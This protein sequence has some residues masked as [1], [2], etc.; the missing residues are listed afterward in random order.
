MQVYMQRLVKT[1]RATPEALMKWQEEW[2]FDVEELAPARL[3]KIWYHLRKISCVPTEVRRLMSGQDACKKPVHEMAPVY[4]VFSEENESQWFT[5]ISFDHEAFS[6]MCGNMRKLWKTEAY[7]GLD[8]SAIPSDA[9]VE[10]TWKFMHYENRHV[11]VEECSDGPVAMAEVLAATPRPHDLCAV[12]LHCERMLGQ[13]PMTLYT[14]VIPNSDYWRSEIVARISE[15][16]FE[17]YML[18][19][20]REQEIIIAFSALADLVY[21]GEIQKACKS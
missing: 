15:T 13:V 9:E 5:A 11:Q 10:R 17:K 1:D 16:E 20:H 8:F 4:I 21:D 19:D 18:T 14:I 6:G 7:D 3:Y 2:G 12:E